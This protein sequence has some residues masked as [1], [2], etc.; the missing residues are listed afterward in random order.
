[1]KPKKIDFVGLL[2]IGAAVWVALSGGGLTWPVIGGSPPFA[3]T[4]PAVLIVEESSDHG[5]Y[6]PDQLTVLQSTDAK[7]V[8]AQL[9][10][11]QFH[12][13]DDDVAADK[14]ALAPAWVQ[15]A[16][17]VKRDSVPWIVGANARTGFSVPL[18]TEADALTRVGGL[19]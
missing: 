12:V 9:G 10:P 8:K 5:K 6:T 7:S 1:M 16:F 11:G 18:T 13:I 14:L 15:E 3:T 17:K 4:V 2:L 19:K